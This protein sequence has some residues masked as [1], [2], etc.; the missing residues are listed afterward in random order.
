MEGAVGWRVDGQLLDFTDVRP[1]PDLRLSCGL[2]H[3]RLSILDLSDSG[4]QPMPGARGRWIV[5]NG[6][7]YNYKELRGEL[8]D[9]G[10]RFV[11]N[12]DTEVLLAAYDQ[13]GAECVSRCNGMWAFAI[14]DPEHG[15]VFCSRDRLGVK[16]F[17]WALDENGS[18]AFAS[19]PETLLTLMGRSRRID[20]TLLGRYLL[21]RVSD[22]RVEGIY[23]DVKQLPPGH[24]GFFTI[25]SG[26]WRDRAYWR[27]PEEADLELS[28]EAALD[29]FEEVF[30]DAVLLRFRSDVPVAITLSG[31]VDSSA[32]A[33]AAFRRG[34]T[35]A[36]YTSHFPEFSD[37]DETA[38]ARQVA[39]AT[40]FEHVL[41]K[42]DFSDMPEGE[43]IWTKCQGLPFGSLSGF[44]HW[45]IMREVR[46]RGITVVLSGQGG[47]ELFWGYESYIPYFVFE[48]LPNAI[49]VIRRW[50][51]AAAR[52]R[53]AGYM[54]PA[55]YAAY[56]MPRLLVLYQARR[57]RDI[58]ARRIIHGGTEFLLEE[59]RRRPM[60]RRSWQKRELFSRSLPSLLR[61]DDRTSG[62]LGMETRLPFL[63]YRLV[64]FASR[65]PW[66][67]T[68]RD[69][70][71]KYL[72]RRYLER[73]GLKELAWRTHKLGFNAPQDAWQRQLWERHGDRLA[74]SPFAASLFKKKIMGQIGSLAG[75]KLWDAYHLLRMAE[76]CGWEMAD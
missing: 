52:I 43:G 21:S 71:T 75:R 47:D 26:E 11:T 58:F 66:R 64:E 39:E 61:Q 73:R 46:S 34:M 23:R 59:N 54:I 74:G 37:I 62:G 65:L 40:G 19:T 16:P 12:T 8:A 76:L 72:T 60:D 24:N 67:H 55:Y 28:D 38:Y 33:V 18:L 32:I 63:D 31:G 3:A 45:S 57:V 69:G 20:P 17:Y 9:L 70:W 41:V 51:A 5:Y 42:P 22:D 27:L 50:R 4:L 2:A 14:Y 68:I 48:P 30:E 1:D 15:E 29:R 56:R 35:P 6:E 25:D 53:I 13:W 36:V 44:I 10:H 7:I 49:S